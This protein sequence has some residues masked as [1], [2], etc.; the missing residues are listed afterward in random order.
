MQVYIV[1]T[2]GV[3]SGLGKGITTASIGKILQAKGF[4][5]TAIKID[6]YINYDA[7]TLRPTEHGEVWVTEDGGEI[8]QDLGHYERFL[9]TTLTKD[10]N[11]TTG[12]VYYQVIMNER[13]GK[14]LGK[15][16]ETIPHVT[17][18]V[19]RRI[20]KIAEKT[21]ADFI[22]VEIGGTVGEYQNLIYYEAMR[23]MK[24]EGEKVIFVHVTYMPVLK[25]LGEPKTKPTQHSVKELRALGIQPDFIVVRSEVPVD[26]PR[27]KKISLFCNVNEEDIISDPDVDLIYEIPLIFEEQD[28]GNKILKKVGLEPRESNLEEWEKFVNKLKNAKESVRVGIVGKYFATGG[29]KLPDAYI[30]VIEAVRHACAFWGVKPEFA[31]IDA[32]EIE[33][34][35]EKVKELNKCDGIIVPGGF[36]STG[37][38]GKILAIKFVREN[39]IPFLGLCFGLQ[40]AVVEFARNV[41]GLKDANSTE[42]NPNTP[43]PVIDILPEQKKLLKECK[44]G[45]T[46]RLGAQPAILKEG[47]LV[48]KLYGKRK[49]VKERHRHRYEVNPAYHEILQKHGLIFSGI[50]PDGRLVEFI[51]LPN[52]P[53]FVATQA[54]PE[55]TSRPLRP[56]PLFVGF[57]KACIERKHAIRDRKARLHKSS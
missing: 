31:W 14:Y 12:Q 45:A 48:W 30:S 9:D 51:E 2:G 36:G 16:V 54:H 50:S 21:K 18:E 37:A 38:E 8:D 6:P 27:R 34:D 19:K 17:D 25:H 52:H 29:F 53:F 44:Y 49:M 23:Q 24:L 39:K 56:N 7:G 28:F 22:L 20:R 42:I 15:T 1:I 47:S 33:R 26:E 55:F 40:L 3:V 46:M 41:C 35:P 32:Q 10:H 57:I 11:I 43:H 5:V 4:K 13:A